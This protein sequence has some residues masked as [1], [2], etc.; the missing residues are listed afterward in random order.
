MERNLYS[1]PAAPVADPGETEEAKGERPAEVT[2]ALRLMWTSVVLSGIELLQQ[3]VLRVSLIFILL[4]SGIPYII[5]G[6]LLY[7]ISRGRHWARVTSLLLWLNTIAFMLFSWRS[8]AAY[9]DGEHSMA[10][11]A[12]VAG[13][14]LDGA[15]IVLLF[16]PAANRWFRRRIDVS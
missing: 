5:V 7:K 1:P 16:V 15:G 4:T 3:R 2:W 11:V 10:A 8:Y 6:W 13:T 14:L 12:T 9:F